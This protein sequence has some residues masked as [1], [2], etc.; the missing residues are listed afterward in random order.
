[1]R[2]LSFFKIHGETLE[3]ADKLAREKL[4]SIPE[5][6]HYEEQIAAMQNQLSTLQS[7]KQDSITA[8]NTSNI[9]EQSVAYSEQAYTAARLGAYSGPILSGSAILEASYGTNDLRLKGNNN[10]KIIVDDS[11]YAKTASGEAWVDYK[12]YA[13]GEYCIYNDSMWKAKTQN[14]GITPVIGAN[15]EKTTIEKELLQLNNSKADTSKI[16]SNLYNT[17]KICPAVLN[18]TNNGSTTMTLDYVA[19]TGR[20]YVYVGNEYKG[21][22]TLTQ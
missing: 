3:I 18:G 1:M 16:P 6:P 4:E 20:V 11:N 8:I 12:T 2:L 13:V 17:S 21:Y 5:L 9:G 10:R 15:W 19:S 14:V 7:T 22:F